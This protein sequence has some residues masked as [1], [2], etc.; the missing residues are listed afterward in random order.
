MMSRIAPPAFVILLLTL[1]AAALVSNRVPPSSEAFGWSFGRAAAAPADRGDQQSV[2]DLTFAAV[3]IDLDTGD[4]PLAAFQVELNTGRPDAKVVGVEEST[5]L[6]FQG[7][8]FFFDGTTISRGRSERVIVA[9]LN[10]GKPDK[11][12]RGVTR[13][14]TINIMYEGK[15][16]PI[17]VTLTAAADAGG[18]AIPAKVSFTM[19]K[20]P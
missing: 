18:N 9:G 11:L 14:A 19:G 12:P 17:G 1:A 5:S 13:I 8:R 7:D 4:S 16:P 15:R 2:G 6:A 10:T 20:Q 3:H